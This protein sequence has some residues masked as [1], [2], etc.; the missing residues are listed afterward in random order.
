MPGTGPCAVWD[1]LETGSLPL[2]NNHN[3]QCKYTPFLDFSLYNELNLLATCVKTWFQ[4]HATFVLPR[5]SR[6]GLQLFQSH[7][8]LPRRNKVVLCSIGTQA[9]A[10]TRSPFSSQRCGYHCT[11][12][13]LSLW[14]STSK[15]YPSQLF[16]IKEMYKSQQASQRKLGIFSPKTGRGEPLRLAT[17]F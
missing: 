17:S 15:N 16:S 10:G 12:T 6:P 5:R 7:L 13:C 1:I 11:S 3:K 4:S 8:S 9:E 14:P 2:A